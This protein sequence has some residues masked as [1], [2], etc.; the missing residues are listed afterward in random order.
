MADYRLDKLTVLKSLPVRPDPYFGAPL[1]RGQH[2]GYRKTAS[3]ENTWIARFTANRQRRSQSLGLHTEVF[4][5][6][7]AKQR[8]QAWFKSVADGSAERAPTLREAATVADACDFYVEHLNSMNRRKTA[9][10]ARPRFAYNVLPHPIAKVRLEQLRIADFDGWRAQLALKAPTYN[11][12]LTALRAALRLMA[13]KERC[14]LD[15]AA[16]LRLLLGRVEKMPLPAGPHRRLVTL[17]RAQRRA[18]LAHCG[19][20][21]FRNLVLAAML[22]GARGGELGAAKVAQFDGSTRTLKLAGKTGERHIPLGAEAVE[23]FRELA[24]DREPDEYLIECDEAWNVRD[25]RPYQCSPFITRADGQVQ[26]RM[27]SAR[28]WCSMFR[29]AAALAALSPQTVLYSLRHTWITEALQNGGGM[30]LLQVARI[31]GTSLEMIDK[32]YGHL[33]QDEVRAQLDKIKM[34]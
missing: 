5:W 23:L 21:G 20:R 27:W 13:D 25:K 19:E 7:E 30:S 10:E 14:S 2:V 28:D 26:R 34:V 11:R 31:T 22:T 16:R 33:Q 3:G 6:E 4:G 24:A 18:L 15:G 17:T 32:H 1:A 29:R 9:N 8:A 12:N